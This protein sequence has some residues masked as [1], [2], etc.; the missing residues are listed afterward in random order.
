VILAGRRSW[1]DRIESLPRL[2]HP[3]PASCTPIRHRVRRR[4]TTTCPRPSALLLSARRE[5]LITNAYIIP[6]ATFMQDLRD[7]ARAA[8][9]CAS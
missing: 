3:G 2:L 9:R 1:D 8:C 5:V 4:C 6:D 7:L